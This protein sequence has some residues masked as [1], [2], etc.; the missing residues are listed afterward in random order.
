MEACVKKVGKLKAARE[1][2]Y[3]F[4]CRLNTPWREWSFLFLSSGLDPLWD[5]PQTDL[6]LKSQSF[7]FSSLLNINI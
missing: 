4:S 2:N 1:D 7:G 5:S 6:G 3:I